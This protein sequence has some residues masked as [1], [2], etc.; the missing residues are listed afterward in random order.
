MTQVS[1]LTLTNQSLLAVEAWSN[2]VCIFIA[3]MAL[4]A[5]VIS[6]IRRPLWSKPRLFGPLKV[7][8][9]VR[10]L[11]RDVLYPVFLFAPNYY[12]LIIWLMKGYMYTIARIFDFSSFVTDTESPVLPDSL[13]SRLVTTTLKLLCNIL[14]STLP[15]TP[16]TTPQGGSEAETDNSKLSQQRGA[17]TATA[18]SG[19]AASQGASAAGD[20]RMDTDDVTSSAA[21]PQTD[22]QVIIKVK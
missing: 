11:I 13:E 12:D 16:T 5:G 10:V 17:D 2:V 6:C 3:A 4:I 9:D 20:Q 18:S 7:A 21:S 19:E 1:M 8:Y 15:P 14:R 22:E